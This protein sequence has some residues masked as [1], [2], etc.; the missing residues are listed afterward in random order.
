MNQ[1][2]TT[3]KWRKRLATLL[4]TGIVGC[5]TNSKTSSDHTPSHADGNEFQQLVDTAQSEGKIPAI[6][7]LVRKDGKILFFGAQG[8]RALRHEA[9]ATTKDEWHLGSDTKAMTAY[10][11]ALAIQEG[12]L[13]YKTEIAKYFSSKTKIHKLNQNL[14][15]G[16][17]LSQ[18]SG[19][20]DIQE[21]KNGDLWKKLWTSTKPLREQRN[22]M[23]RASL[24]ESPHMSAE[25]PS[26]AE[27]KF[28]YANI[29]YITAGAILENLYNAEWEQII[30]DRLFKPLNMTSCGFGVSGEVSETEPSQPWPHVSE[31]G[32]LISVPPKHK[33]DNPPFVGP[34]GTVHCSLEDWEKFVG[35]LQNAWHGKGALLRNKDVSKQYFAAAPGSPYTYGGWGRKEEPFATS[36]FEH[37]GSNTFNYAVAFFAP[38]KN[39]TVL[40]VANSGQPD[41][42]KALGHLKKAI[43][44]K[45]LSP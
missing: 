12:R 26:K 1:V 17:I 40:L 13:S 28:N 5:A 7:V 38:E 8:K 33:I 2:R 18:G 22:E 20:K 45:L 36:T 32:E 42:G 44:L 9:D 30:S 37:D 43:A 3:K 14:T 21:V 34:A 25:T 39:L 27:R 24:E 23:V 11:M 15:L 31:G 4:A 19:L 29:N 41:V 35:E 16:D 6:G 10:L